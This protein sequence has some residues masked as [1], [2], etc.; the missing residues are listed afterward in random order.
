MVPLLLLEW[1]IEPLPFVPASSFLLFSHPTTA[2]AN[3]AARAT[4]PILFSMTRILS[5]LP[6]HR[7]RRRK[8]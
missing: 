2:A 1:F 8:T 7:N 4:D 3:A 6:H 5:R